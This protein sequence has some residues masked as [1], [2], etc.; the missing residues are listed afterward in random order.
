MIVIGLD[1]I[2][3]RWVDDYPGD[4]YRISS[5][6]SEGRSCPITWEA[7]PSMYTGMNGQEM[8]TEGLSGRSMFTIF[9]KFDSRRPDLFDDISKQKTMASFRMPMTYPAREVNGWMVSG[10]PLPEGPKDAAVYG[11]DV[12]QKYKDIVPFR[13]PY[14]SE[15]VAFTDIEERKEACNY[16]VDLFLDMVSD[17]D[18][19]FFGSQFPDHMGHLYHH[20]KVQPE[21]DVSEYYRTSNFRDI[22]VGFGMDMAERI[23]DSLDHEDFVIVSD[24]GYQT[25]GHSDFSTLITNLDASD[26]ES[27]R[28]I[29]NFITDSLGISKTTRQYGRNLE[30]DGSTKEQLESWGYL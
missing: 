9:D 12:P 4:K 20:R 22:G 8:G 16:L 28:D 19:V 29:R 30:A 24:H 11:T 15:E 10:F 2:D 14:D 3:P 17:E 6:K 13:G 7:W 26:V 5:Y 27:I 21:Y 18:V 23:I 1:G 25:S